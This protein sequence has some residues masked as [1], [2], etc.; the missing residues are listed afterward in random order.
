M[1]AN[2][3][4]LLLFYTSWFGG[5]PQHDQL[6]SVRWTRDR[7][8]LA[9]ADIVLFHIPDLPLREFTSAR[10]YAGQ[11]WVAWTLESS[12]NYPQLDNPALMRLFDVV[13]TYDR[14]SDVWL[15]YVPRL[16]DWHAALS[17]PV[18]P[19]TEKVPVALFQ[20]ATI[21][22]CG[23]NAFA[24]ELMDHIAVDSYGRFRNN[25][26]LPEPDRGGSTKSTVISRY[27]FCLA[28]ENSRATDYVTE[29]LYGPLLAGT[30][31]VYRGAPNVAE[32]APGADSY[33]DAD[34]FAGPKQ[35]AE[36]LTHLV[37]TPA[38]YAAY[39]AWRQRPLT[40]FLQSAARSAENR[41]FEGLVDFVAGRFPPYPGPVNLPWQPF[42]FLDYVRVR[43]AERRAE[44]LREHAARA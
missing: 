25:R 2:R 21:D 35:L 26:Q 32:F 10:K 8:Q 29:K 36:F 14:R 1:N 38:E 40:P 37:N 5:D 3:E 17:R 22:R 18:A 41:W 27:H 19:K 39:F 34:A 28:F 44:R 16:S 9:E 4:P 30:V 33:I 13:M 42:R 7:R 23:R 15:P 11:L 24:A 12:V 43:R 31:P 20:S 6:G